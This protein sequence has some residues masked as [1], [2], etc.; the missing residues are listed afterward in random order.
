MSV[1]AIHHLGYLCVVARVQRGELASPTADLWVVRVFA[2]AVGEDRPDGVELAVFSQQ[3]RATE[4]SRFEVPD[5]HALTVAA[6]I[7]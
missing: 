6:A 4:R 2:S 1:A 7:P 3:V 5:P